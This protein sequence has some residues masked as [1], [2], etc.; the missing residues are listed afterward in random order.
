MVI[1]CI[2]T[3]EERGVKMENKQNNKRENFVKISENRVNKILTLFSQLTNL[4]NTSYYE[5][6][7][8]DIEKMFSAI[9]Y[10]MN[11]SKQM[12]LNSK[13]KNKRFEI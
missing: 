8:E 10:E 1:F 9:E 5:Y 2:I 11:K 3:N 7:E 6:T 13:R 12:L 4:S